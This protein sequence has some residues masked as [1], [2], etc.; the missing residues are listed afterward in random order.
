[1]H[2]LIFNKNRY[3]YN[4]IQKLYVVL[5]EMHDDPIVDA[6]AAEFLLYDTGRW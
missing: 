3:L 4:T 6:F 5:R 1:V 2:I